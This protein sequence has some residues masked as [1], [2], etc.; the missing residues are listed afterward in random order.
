MLYTINKSRT[1]KYNKLQGAVVYTYQSSCSLAAP[2]RHPWPAST[3]GTA[4]RG[5]AQSATSKAGSFITQLECLGAAGELISEHQAAKLRHPAVVVHPNAEAPGLAVVGFNSIRV[6]HG[7]SAVVK[8]PGSASGGLGLCPF[9]WL[10]K[11]S[12][13]RGYLSPLTIR[14]AYRTHKIH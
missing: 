6:V 4:D 9:G 3:Y 8:V 13:S 1:L 7:I 14:P 5:D 10:V 11:C 12:S 2:A